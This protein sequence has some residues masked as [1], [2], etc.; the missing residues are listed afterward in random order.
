M[1][2]NDVISN[3]IKIST[4]VNTVYIF[5]VLPEHRFCVNLVP[6]LMGKVPMSEYF[7]Q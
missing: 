4:V 3:I 6:E 2:V 1:L 5:F 7:E